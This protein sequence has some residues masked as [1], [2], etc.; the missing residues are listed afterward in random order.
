MFHLR[1]PQALDR[2]LKLGKLAGLQTFDFAALETKHMV[3]V[4]LGMR[5]EL[6]TGYAVAE[7][8]SSNDPDLFEVGQIPIKRDTVHISFGESSMDLVFTERPMIPDQEA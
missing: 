6:V 1:V 4:V 2:G 5:L 7:L 8:T 3:M